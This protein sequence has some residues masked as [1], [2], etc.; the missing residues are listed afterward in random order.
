MVKNLEQLNSQDQEAPQEQTPQKSNRPDGAGPLPE[1]SLW[2]PKIVR[3]KDGQQ[4]ESSVKSPDGKTYEIKDGEQ[5][6]V[7][8]GENGDYEAAI[9]DKDGKKIY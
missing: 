2:Q 9:V 7:E 1:W 4:R 6:V 5:F 3:G 8:R